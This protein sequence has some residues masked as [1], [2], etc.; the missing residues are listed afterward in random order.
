MPLDPA[1]K[2]AWIKEL[3]LHGFVVLRGFL[4]VDF[5]AALAAQMDPI[6]RGEYERALA[7]ASQTRRGAHRL[8]FDVARYADLLGGPLADAR[9]RSNPDVEEM[10]E[11]IL[12]PRGGW[13]YGW[14]RAEASWKGSDY[15]AWHT[16]Q[17][18]D[19]TP[20]PGAPNRTV[21]M[22]FNIPIT[23][24]TWANGATQFVPGSHLQAWNFLN[25]DFLDLPNLHT[26][27]PTLMPGDCLLRD[28][29]TLHR[30]TPNL[31]SSVRAMLDQT[32]R[33][34]KAIATS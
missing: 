25:D 1:R 11:A 9:Y 8:S 22:T 30:G 5:V 7:G 19:E 17:V 24:F 3:R 10:V 34:A 6:L 4:P 26:A 28:G 15:M 14:S 2:A 20:D 13:G 21:R 12:G 18:L 31:T 16:D 32:Y 29:N 33:V 27:Q 23:P